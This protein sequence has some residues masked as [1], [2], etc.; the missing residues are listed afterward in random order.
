MVTLDK[1]HEAVPASSD[2]TRLLDLQCLISITLTL[3][4]HG[5]LAF[6]FLN[7]Y[8]AVQEWLLEWLLTYVWEAADICT[9]SSILAVATGCDYGHC[10][11]HAGLSPLAHGLLH[12]AGVSARYVESCSPIPARVVRAAAQLQSWR[13]DRALKRMCLLEG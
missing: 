11:L 6:T 12:C 2:L 5:M 7:P 1:W 8:Y 3:V 9:E 10:L 4:A 13:H